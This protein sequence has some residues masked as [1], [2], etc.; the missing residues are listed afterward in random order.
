M[1]DG[2]VIRRCMAVPFFL[3]PW[4][5]G[6]SDTASPFSMAIFGAGGG[7]VS[8]VILSNMPLIGKFFIANVN[9]DMNNR[10]ITR[11]TEADSNVSLLQ[12]PGMPGESAGS[13]KHY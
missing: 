5:D 12:P 4:S 3:E 10:D 1:D 11:T 8:G 13:W 9:A 2:N 7:A 6:R